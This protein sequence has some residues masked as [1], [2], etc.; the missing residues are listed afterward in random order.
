M[1]ELGELERLGARGAG[2]EVAAQARRELRLG[3]GERG[4]GRQQQAR[5]VA[6]GRKNPAQL[7]VEREAHAGLRE[8]G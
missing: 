6:A 8:Q 7:R 3:L 1:R 2:R 4:R 5:V